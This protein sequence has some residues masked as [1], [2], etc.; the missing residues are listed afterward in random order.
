MH[1][2]SHYEVTSPRDYHK[3]AS[4]SPRD[5]GLKQEKADKDRMRDLDSDLSA[6]VMYNKRKQNYIFH[7]I[8]IKSLFLFSR[9][10][11]CYMYNACQNGAI[12]MYNFIGTKQC[13]TMYK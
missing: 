7:N 5:W 12:I 11:A 2:Q 4:S 8:F 10:H 1:T 9:V 6:E 13:I 3:T